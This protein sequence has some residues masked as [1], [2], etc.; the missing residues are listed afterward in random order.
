[1][2]IKR[3]L[4][5]IPI[6]LLLFGCKKG[7]DVKPEGE[8][9]VNSKV[10]SSGYIGTVV[11]IF[12]GHGYDPA[13]FELQG[14]FPGARG[15]MAKKQNSRKIDG[16]NYAIPLTKEKGEASLKI[17]KGEYTL[18]FYSVITSRP[19]GGGIPLR[20][21]SWRSKEIRVKSGETTKITFAP[22]NLYQRGYVDEAI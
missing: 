7:Q 13:T 14:E 22:E 8:I 19:W 17:N 5:I 4:F 18:I 12:D 2:N 20:Y 1:M 16:L 10:K 15:K 3:I 6:I 9:S 11:H 21:D